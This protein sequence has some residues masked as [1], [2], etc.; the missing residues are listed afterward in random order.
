MELR[1]GEPGQQL[2]A[3]SALAK[4]QNYFTLLTSRGSQPPVILATEAPAPI[5]ASLGTCTY[6]STNT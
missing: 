6:K 1:D 4:D 2:T 5:F 3:K